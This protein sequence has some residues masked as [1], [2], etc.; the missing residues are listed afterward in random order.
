[1]CGIPSITLLGAE[2][3]WA[4]LVTR[5]QPI[6]SGQFGD[7]DPALIQ[8]GYMLQV[9]LTR[10]QRAFVDSIGDQDWKG[11]QDRDFWTSVV[12]YKRNYSERGA[13]PDNEG[14]IGGW[15]TAFTRW[16]PTALPPDATSEGAKS[17]LP[18]GASL[19]DSVEVLPDED[20]PS[21][22]PQYSISTDSGVVSF[23]LLRPSRIPSSLAVLPFKLTDNGLTVEARLLAGHIGKTWFGMKEDRV[24]PLPGW[25]LYLPV[26]PEQRNRAKSPTPEKTEDWTGLGGA[27]KRANTL[28]TRMMADGGGPAP[29]KP[30]HQTSQSLSYP[31]GAGP[32][33]SSVYYPGVGEKVG[34]AMGIHVADSGN[35]VVG[36]GAYGVYAPTDPRAGGDSSAS[37]GAGK[38]KIWQ[39][40]SSHMRKWSRSDAKG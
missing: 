8:W 10:F 33:G 37:A 14:R 34:G 24:Q 26:P 16:T 25:L 6:V 23:P 18:S 12:R 31:L 39:K 7:N 20:A 19:F 22:S 17:K 30:T 9:I 5:I 1:M 32:G 3:D 15:I 27:V 28:K 29:R 13:A 11:G 36:P 35:V 40:V 2:P 38:A 21:N 4:D